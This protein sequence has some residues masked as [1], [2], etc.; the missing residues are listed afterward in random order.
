MRS[1]GANR[2]L[3]PTIRMVRHV[4]HGFHV[5]LPGPS[6]EAQRVI[7]AA[8]FIHGIGLAGAGRIRYLKPDLPAKDF[9][10]IEREPRDA[11]LY[12]AATHTTHVGGLVDNVAR[13]ASR[14][15]NHA[16]RATPPRERMSCH[17]GVFGF[18]HMHGLRAKPLC[19]R[20]S[21]L[22]V[23]LTQDGC[24]STVLLPHARRYR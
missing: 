3:N 9:F 20:Q 17:D 10:A 19:Q 23:A 1:C 5:A 7:D 12:Y 8:L 11:D 21:V 4:R 6:H 18:P 24:Y 2:R 16:V 22:I 15:H 14:A 13:T